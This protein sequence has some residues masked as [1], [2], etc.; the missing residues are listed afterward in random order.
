M[1]APE[2]GTAFA[3]QQLRALPKIALH[4]HLDGGLRPRT[5]LEL[6]NR[7]GL[8]PPAPTPAG[9]EQWFWSSADSGSL[10]SYLETFSR[11][12]AVM[13]SAENLTRI[14]R[15]FVEDMAADSVIYAETRWAPQLH[16]AGGLSAEA[17]VDAVQRGLDEGM[18]AISLSGGTMLA[19][20]VLI[21]LRSHDPG[22]VVAELVVDRLGR[23]VVGYDLAGPE[24]GY[25][26]TRWLAACRHVIDNG[27]HVT[28][29]AGEGAG[30]ESVR[31][32]LA[33]GAQ[34]LGHGVRLVEDISD[35]VLGEVARTVLER[36]IV[37]E[38]CPSSNHQTGLSTGFADHP[39]RILAE[40]G[41]RLTVSCD[42]RLM[43]RTTLSRELAQVATGM[44]W[45]LE[46]MRALQVT[47]LEAAFCTAH[48]KAAL[49]TL[50][51]GGWGPIGQ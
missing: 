21:D 9:I 10:P 37:L 15:E 19:R 20:Q 16:T 4:D 31:E 45:G 35:G 50:L 11:T 47:A 28:I 5:V 23:G 51:D 49:R 33:C 1:S 22:N 34:R 12:L 44:G 3:L 24:Q 48:E 42:N 30:I 46:R 27:G 41:F 2:T 29:H 32:A 40:S 36:G 26:A 25:P 43:S 13:Q 14:A 38:V 6:A 17:A 7:A 39:F 8:T 18:A